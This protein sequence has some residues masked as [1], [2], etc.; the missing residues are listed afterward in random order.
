MDRKYVTLKNRKKILLRYLQRADLN[1]IWKNFNDVVDEKEYLPTFSKVELEY[2]KVVWYREMTEEE[3]NFCV[4]AEDISGKPPYNIAGQCTVENI[5][6]EAS[7]HVGMLGI[8]IRKD[9]RNLGLGFHLINFAIE[10]AR[11]LG[12][13]KL[14]LSTFA[15][16]KHAISL[17]KKIGFE[18][19][20]LRKKQF[21]MF[22]KYIDEILMDLWIG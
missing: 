7:A 15:T 20:G 3:G 4:V 8:I 9:Y 13:K 1:A 11:K 16:N 10:Q 14:I 22:G 5:E 21:F 18:E 17:Y 19:I 12:K 6:W 2:E